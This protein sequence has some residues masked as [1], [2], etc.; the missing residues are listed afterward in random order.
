M[1]ARLGS[2]CFRRRWVRRDRCG[3]SASSSSAA[4]SSA[5]GGDFGQD[6]TPLG[7]REHPRPRHPRGG[8]RRLRRRH[9]RHDRVPRR[10]GRRRPRGRG[11]D[12]AA[13][14]HR[15]GDRR[16]PRRRL[17]DPLRLAQRR[18]ARRA[19]GRRPRGVGG[20]DPRQPLR[21]DAR[22]ADR[23]RGSG[24][25]QDRLRLLEIPGDDWADAGA[26]RPH[27]SQ[28]LFPEIDGAA[29]RARRRRLRRVR[30]AGVRGARPGLRHRDPRRR[31]RFRAGH[32]PAHRR[33]ARRD[34][35]RLDDRHDP[36][37]H[38]P[39]ARLRASSSA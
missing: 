6:F 33:G 26:D 13:V 24:G 30:G 23:H 12:D 14:H 36:L 10:A 7:L 27:R 31:V 37:E 28:E 16:R 35:R 20:D 4:S 9:P 22:A 11:A 8:D 3:S 34:H 29:G 17:S 38:L 1:F 18:A 39:D 25:R 19:R 32:G 2:W 5:M 21:A 15:P